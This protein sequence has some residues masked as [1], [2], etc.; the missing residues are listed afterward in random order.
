MTF[1]GNQDFLFE[2]A[3]GN[4]EGMKAYVVPGRRDGVS[5]LG[6][7]DITQIPST[8]AIFAIPD[9][10]GQ[11]LEVLSDDSNDVAA[12]SGVQTMELEFLD[13]NGDEQF[14]DIVMNGT[15]PVPT[16]ST[17]IGKVQWMHGIEVGSNTV[18]EGNI[19]LRQSTAAGGEVYEYVALGG[20]Q[21][22][23][24]RYTVPNKK[25]GYIMGW[26]A[27][28]IIK[29]IDFRLRATVDRFRRTSQQAFNFQDAVVVDD[30][31]S[32]WLNFEV[33]LKCP[34]GSQIKASGVSAAAGGD[35]GC[36]F[37]ILL[38]DDDAKVK[39]RNTRLR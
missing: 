17:D 8:A 20:N 14:E 24:C 3:Q 21:S 34:A 18:S 31:L 33:P 22:L 30:G 11:Q 26:Q 39:P 5:A 36:Q 15:S 29:V 4:V 16:S 32:G 25:T 13:S 27:S 2:I 38:V 6:L 7:A 1:W 35:A 28:G 23:S 9:P 19:T 12:G 10:N 37:H